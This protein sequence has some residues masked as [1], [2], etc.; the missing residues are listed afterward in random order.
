MHKHSKRVVS[1]VITLT[2]ILSLFSVSFG[3]VSAKTLDI[4]EASK[5]AS[6]SSADYD[7]G[8][9]AESKGGV[10][11]HAWNWYFNDVTERME[12]IARAG[13]KTVQVSPVQLS[14]EDGEYL[15][16]RN[17]WW[18]LYQPL[19]FSVG[20][21]LGTKEEFSKMCTTAHKYGVN[22]I[23]DVVTNHM[24][25]G[26]AGA[27]GDC[28][29]N[30]NLTVSYNGKEYNII[31]N[32][33]FWHD[34]SVTNSDNSRTEMT[35]GNIGMPDLNTSMPQVQELVL[36]LLKE[37]VDL[38]ADG[39]RYDALKHIETD[40]AVDQAAGVASDFWKNTA[41]AVSEYTDTT[42]NGKKL[43]HYGEVIAP[44]Y[45][46]TSGGKNTNSA[47]ILNDGYLKYLDGLTD[48]G[49][50]YWVREDIKDNIINRMSPN[51][52]SN[53]FASGGAGAYCGTMWYGIE[54]AGD[55]VMWVE[56]HDT[57]A[58]DT[59]ENGS[60][61]AGVLT[62]KPL[63]ENDIKLGW[64]M[65]NTRAYVTT[66]FFV[67][68]LGFSD[69]QSSNFG[70]DG[71][72]TLYLNN[73]IVALNQFHNYF[74]G[75]SFESVVAPQNGT[76]YSVERYN[77]KTSTAG[78]VITNVGTSEV[79]LSVS[80]QKFANGTYKD[81]ISGKSYT[82]S[83]GK[84]TG[85]LPAKSFIMLYSK[86]VSNHSEPKAT[87]SQEGGQF[88]TSLDLTLNLENATSG[89]YTIGNGTP[90]AFDDE[91]D[92][93]IGEDVATGEYVAV[94]LTA[95]NSDKTVTDTYVFTKC[96]PVAE[97]AEVYFIYSGTQKPT[98]VK[99][100]FDDCIK[101]IN[102]GNAK[103]V[104]GTYVETISATENLEEHGFD[105]GVNYVMSKYDSTENH[106]VYK[107]SIPNNCEYGKLNIT[108]N[109]GGTTKTIPTGATLSDPEGY[110]IT[111]A[112]GST[113]SW[114]TAD[115]NL[116]NKTMV[117]FDYRKGYAEAKT[118]DDYNLIIKNSYAA[119]VSADGGE[120]TNEYSYIP[121]DTSI[122]GQQI[123]YTANRKQ[124]LLGSIIK[125]TAYDG[126]NDFEGWYNADT[127]TLIT[128]SRSITL[129][130]YQDINIKAVYSTAATGDLSGDG[131]INLMD[132][133][134][135]TAKS[136]FT[137][138]EMKAGDINKDGVVDSKDAVYILEQLADVSKMLAAYTLKVAS[139]SNGTID[140]VYNAIYAK[141]YT[142]SLT[143]TPD[144]HYI[145]AGWK[146][147]DGTL[148]S[149]NVSYS[150]NLQNDTDLT[151]TFEKAPTYTV[152]ITS[153]ENGTISNSIVNQ[154]LYADDTVTVTATPADGYHFKGWYD[155]NEDIYIS[156]DTTL[157]LN[158]IT[159][160]IDYTAVFSNTYTVVVKAEDGGTVSSDDI[161]IGKENEVTDGTTIEL[162]VDVLDGYEFAGWYT[163]SGLIAEDDVYEFVVTS[164]MTITA[165]F[166]SLGKI[167]Y[168]YNESDW[169]DVRIHA[170]ETGGAAYAEW[171]SDE[172]KMT[173]V[174][175]GVPENYT[176]DVYSFTF[177]A[178]AKYDNVIFYNYTT[179]AQT[180]DQ[181]IYGDDATGK[182]NTFCPTNE[183]WFA[184]GSE[185]THSSSS[186]GDTSGETTL[187]FSNNQG[188]TT[189]KVYAYNSKT[190]AEM[191]TWNNSVSATYVSTNSY[192]EKIYKC[193]ISSKYDTVIFHNGSGEQTVN[194]SYL[195]CDGDN[196]FYPVSKNT[197]GKWTVGHCKY[198]A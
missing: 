189:V 64:A 198:S 55:M 76:T 28:D 49:T 187:Y 174:T 40:C 77:S 99:F 108:L 54:N 71:S 67:R 140:E 147:A 11:L 143:A 194:I 17:N 90:V 114:V 122:P 31:D 134:I 27:N 20:N 193:T 153:G 14:K 43:Y 131:I 73:D 78:I 183:E 148:A 130:V 62:S 18:K 66:L 145:F 138:S 156:N 171:G 68:P 1:I 142:V 179:G 69:A 168:F 25:G 106:Y 115:F 36:G 137:D 10:I 163:D 75:E 98:S 83:G 21:L 86:N 51:S 127:N 197:S 79:T 109:V 175:E 104:T 52:D 165:K 141:N 84:V 101:R 37:C 170:W 33:I 113:T 161:T 47:S 61:G 139:S 95:S 87:I 97:A 176:H 112:S 12:E 41:K 116:Y 182:T 85:K 192:G 45:P 172:A 44:V 158:G 2:M 8:L 186:G 117:C 173:K 80:T 81:I 195:E 23:V 56:S 125:T 88:E 91:T 42:Y 13:Y 4:S 38:G 166:N 190:G 121:F 46:N 154:T 22:I 102:T 185:H 111:N 5:N 59:Y 30:I 6:D 74:Y 136:T 100:N 178:S 181:T 152:N 24:S 60:T 35:Q 110:R 105:L 107:C 16:V 177:D 149:E 48:V 162:T 124:F 93:T 65:L 72:T 150:F 34:P 180:D 155:N 120:I 103:T 53:A 96:A 126:E 39:F 92:I 132:A 119:N 7:F 135:I 196:Q 188:W 167:V 82:V 32:K 94:T 15:D 50:G 133:Y 57:Y 3:N 26:N 19:N 29:E 160:D 70:A 144:K 151:A 157:T 164:D 184:F 129:P 9:P 128:S 123:D 58:E 146:N 118:L 63:S 191:S 169:T 159:S 89:T